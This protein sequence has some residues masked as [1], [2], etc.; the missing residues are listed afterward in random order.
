MGIDGQKPPCSL[1]FRLSLQLHMAVGDFDGEF[2]VLAAVLFADLFGLFVHESA[3]GIEGA[4]DI[5]SG[6]LFGGDQFVVEAL[7][8]CAIGLVDLI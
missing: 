6:L 3:K 1:R 8:F 4:G 5:F 7:D 2:H